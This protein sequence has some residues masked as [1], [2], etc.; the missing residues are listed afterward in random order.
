M[1]THRRIDI[2]K[3]EEFLTYLSP[4]H[5]M[6]AKGNYDL[7]FRGQ[8][9]SEW[10][11]LPSAFRPGV[12]FLFNGKKGIQK[13]NDAQRRAEQFIIL[14]FYRAADEQGL[15]IPEDCVELRRR[16]YTPY[17]AQMLPEI[18][19]KNGIGG[20]DKVEDWPPQE[21]WSL[22]GLAQH[23][24]LPT[25]FLDWTR[26]SI[27]AA[28][29][30]TKDVTKRLSEGMSVSER[31]GVW[32]LRS[33][34]PESENMQTQPKVALITPPT[35]GNPNLRAQKG[36]FTLHI[37]DSARPEDPVDTR[38]IDQV[39]TSIEPIGIVKFMTDM[40]GQRMYLLTLPTS[41]AGRLFTLLGRTGISASTMFPG[42]GGVAE[43]IRE[44]AWNSSN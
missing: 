6:W 27:V 43:S 8:A 40:A 23:H 32:I 9:N 1:E 12:N 28:Y 41:E 5:A 4:G 29:F 42:F 14:K 44:T 18:V 16:W 39:I 38:P 37:P 24:G 13:S 31:L 11:L 3:A 35:S 22:I 10:P 7:I 21:L 33:S 15:E 25:R 26:N 17:S 2:D 34:I 20:G 36:V 19:V 30:A